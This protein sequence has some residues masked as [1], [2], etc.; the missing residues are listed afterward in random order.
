MSLVSRI[1]W[2]GILSTF[3]MSAMWAQGS[4]PGTAGSASNKDGA[5]VFVIKNETKKMQ[6]MLR[7]K[8]HYQGKVD[9]VLGLRTRASIRAYQKAETLPITGHV[10]TRTADGLGIRPESS[11]GDSRSAGPG[12]ERGSGWTTSEVGRNKPS[13]GIRR[14]GGRATKAW[15][16]DVSTPKDDALNKH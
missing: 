6:Q 2:V 7:N 9:G 12:T 13:A 4:P 3:L 16:K 11:W 8:G 1:G 10:D 14:A 5:E 15:R